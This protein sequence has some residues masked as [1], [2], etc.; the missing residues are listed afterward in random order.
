M[1]R[2]IVNA[3]KHRGS[4]DYGCDFLAM[5]E[6]QLELGHVRLSIIDLSENGHQP[7]FCRNLV[8]FFNGE[9]YNFKKL[10]APYMIRDMSLYQNYLLRLHVYFK[11]S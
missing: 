10:E 4:D 11:Q 5:S 8:I 2:R 9:I 1:L 6:C 3:L 7:M